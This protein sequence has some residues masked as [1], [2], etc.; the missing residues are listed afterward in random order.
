MRTVATMTRADLGAFVQSHLR[1]KGI[2]MVLGGGACVSIYSQNKYSSMDLDMIHSSLMAP[3][4]KLIRDAMGEL[5]FVEVGR[6]FT[7]ADT[8]LFVDFVA[9]PPAVGEEPVKDIQERHEASGILRII[10]PTDC[11]KDRLTGFY[12]DN[13]QQCL[14]QAILVAQ[15]NAISLSEIERWSKGEGKSD[16]FKQ[17]REQLEGKKA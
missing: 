16:L 11:V 12:H 4:R 10:S 17:I 6:Y 15:D 5:G 2:D 13:D 3:K 8:D 1:N 14:D 9:G 7:H